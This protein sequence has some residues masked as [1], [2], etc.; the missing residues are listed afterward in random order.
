[1][2]TCTLCNEVKPLDEFHRWNGKRHPRCKPCRASSRKGSDGDRRDQ[3]LRALYGITITEY[4]A[5]VTAQGGKC[6]VCDISAAKAVRGRLYVDHDH[7]TGLIR[8]LLCSHCNTGLGLFRDSPELLAAAI[9]YLR[10]Q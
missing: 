3:H 5:M 8:G 10:K 1:M 6:L 2:Q 4:N 9:S 7:A